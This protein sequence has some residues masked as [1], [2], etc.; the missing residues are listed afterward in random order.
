MS[1]KHAK[2]LDDKQFAKLLAKVSAGEHG[3]RDR[4]MMLLSYKAGLRAQEIAG[5]EWSAMTDADGDVIVP[6]QDDSE[7]GDT[8]FTI[9]SHI[10]KKGHERTVPMHPMLYGALLA[11]REARPNDIYLIYGIRSE[12][13]T[14]N[15]VT[16]WFH[17][18][19]SVQGLKGCSSHSGR[20]TFITTAARRCNLH[21]CS[22]KDVQL[23]AGHKRLETTEAY[24]EAS[25]SVHRLMAAL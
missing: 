10:A 21:G 7:D 6:K 16:V 11:L 13:M 8:G 19:Y 9:G 24:L 14:P 12:R 4:V 2:V 17:R 20:R 18:L 3:L 15:H 25:A 1:I 23:L 22:L 5:L